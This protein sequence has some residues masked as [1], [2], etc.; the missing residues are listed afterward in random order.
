MLVVLFALIC[1]I[2]SLLFTAAGAWPVALFLGVDVALLYL[3]FRLNTR[4]A[5]R[6]E[7]VQV[8]RSAVTLTQYDVRGRSRYRDFAP[9]WVRVELSES[10]DGRT[11]LALASGPER[12]V[13]GE[14]LTDDERRDFAGVLDDAILRARGAPR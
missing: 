4:D 9:S 11:V 7:T 10:G 12:M 8:S 1:S 13:F 3:A 14:F 6:Y 5:R 2:A